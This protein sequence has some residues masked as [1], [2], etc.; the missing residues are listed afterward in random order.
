[1]ERVAIIGLG[2]IGGS[3]ALAL[4]ELSAVEAEIVGFSR[5][6]E[7]V[8]RAE[9]RGIID[10]SASNLKAAVDGADLVVIS[11]PVITIEE[12]LKKISAH[13]SPGCVVTDTGSTK[14]KVM[15]WA[16]E[17]LPGNVNFVGGHPMAG[18]ETSGLNEATADL[19][20]GCVYCLT[21][22]AGAASEA[23]QE[24]EK[25]VT[26]IGARPFIIDA[27][28]H[29]RLVAGVSHLPML[30][31]AAFVSAT[32]QSP[33]WP[34]MAELAAGGYRDLSR[35]AAGNPEMNRDICITNRDDIVKWIDRFIEELQ[36]YS[37]MIQ[38]GGGE[39]KDALGRAR[40]ARERWMEG[41]CR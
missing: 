34:E 32:I 24:V 41:E 39:L 13:L 4:K 21:P 10:R 23:V 9:K 3:L 2:L 1:M 15:G 26:S 35:L 27:G 20:R 11:T 36:R 16:E 40:E 29:D 8:S 7:T 30:L 5:R 22:A 37:Q 12:V 33:L 6:P 18:K 28:A 31:S 19:F 38:G 17:Y 25:L 14:A